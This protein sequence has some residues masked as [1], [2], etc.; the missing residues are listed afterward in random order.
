MVLEIDVAVDAALCRMHDVVGED[1]VAVIPSVADG[2]DALLP[3]G[4]EGSAEEITRFVFGE[5]KGVQG[6]EELEVLPGGVC[7]LLARLRRGD[8]QDVRGRQDH[9]AGRVVAYSKAR[10]G[11]V[12]ERGLRDLRNRAEGGKA[13]Q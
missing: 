8:R 7:P 1:A 4:E 10:S 5:A 3:L 6:S 12:R 13:E 11:G 9:R 2:R